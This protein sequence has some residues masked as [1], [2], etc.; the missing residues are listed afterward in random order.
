MNLENFIQLC[1]THK[2]EAEYF[3]LTDAYDAI[4]E[5]GIEL[6][7][8][9]AKSCYQIYNSGKEHGR[10]ECLRKD[11]SSY[12]HPGSIDSCAW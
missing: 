7:E 5:S 6:N 9:N 11:A 1:K 10:K 3:C 4:I 2:T 8:H 12:L